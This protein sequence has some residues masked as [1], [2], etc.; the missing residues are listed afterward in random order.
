VKDAT[1]S[2]PATRIIPIVS[3]LMMQS[4]ACGGNG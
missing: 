3:L 2:E 1:R 4:S